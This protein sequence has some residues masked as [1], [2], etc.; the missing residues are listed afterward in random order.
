MWWC[1]G[2]EQEQTLLP[3]AWEELKA[4]HGVILSASADS[5]KN[6]TTADIHI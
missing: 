4:T 5:P 3:E 2:V 1:V 6:I